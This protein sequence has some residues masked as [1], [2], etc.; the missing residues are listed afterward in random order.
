M[1]HGGGLAIRGEQFLIPRRFILPRERAAT[2]RIVPGRQADFI[3]VIHAR[4]ARHS[5]L[6]QGAEPQRAD[7]IA[8]NPQ[9]A[10]G[11]VAVK[12]I[13]LRVI[14]FPIVHAVHG[15]HPCG[16]GRSVKRL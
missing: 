6:K 1:A 12:Q 9:R 11:V 3:A 15:V 16:K 2:R 4:R 13:Q 14:D 10:G 8:H 5:H 7:I